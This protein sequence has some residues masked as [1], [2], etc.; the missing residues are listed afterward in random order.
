ML[1]SFTST[2][3]P[4][5]SQLF[6]VMANLRWEVTYYISIVSWVYTGYIK[7]VSYTPWSEM[8]WE[9]YLS[10]QANAQIVICLKT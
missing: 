6:N 7:H 9:A 1:T 10:N 3:M 2:Y 5:K 8:Y 4:L